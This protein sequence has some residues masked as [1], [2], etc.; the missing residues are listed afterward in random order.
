MGNDEH[1]SHK[2]GLIGELLVKLWLN[3]YGANTGGVDKDTGTD[4]VIFVGGRILTAQVKSG[5]NAWNS[6]EVH[7]VDIHFQVNL[8]H[9][10][11][12]NFV[13]QE[14]SIRWRPANTDEAFE[15]FIRAS[16]DKFIELK[17]ET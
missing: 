5:I 4:I 14:S 11:A 10:A 17:S 15:P 6:G 16:L 7:G 8:R 13:I 1:E 9:D 2:T 3:A 12:D